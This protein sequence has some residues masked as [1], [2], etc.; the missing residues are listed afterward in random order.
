MDLSPIL[1]KTVESGRLLQLE[2]GQIG[3]DFRLDEQRR[4][5]LDDDDSVRKS[6]RWSCRQTWQSLS[7]GLSVRALRDRGVDA[8]H[9]LRRLGDERDQVL[10]HYLEPIL[11]SNSGTHSLRQ[12]GEGA[13][14]WPINGWGSLSRFNDDDSLTYLAGF[15]RPA[16]S[17]T[18]TTFNFDMC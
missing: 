15:Q 6:S 5:G 9:V 4:A 10:P 12:G 13:C 17:L 7:Q 3:P 14:R 18:M 8:L 16:P 1:W 2:I 11:G